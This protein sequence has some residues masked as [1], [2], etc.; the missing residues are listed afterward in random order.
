MKVLFCEQAHLCN[1]IDPVRAICAV[2]RKMRVPLCCEQLLE[3][4]SLSP[5]KSIHSNTD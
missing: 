4:V 2:A 1:L 3:N 5:P